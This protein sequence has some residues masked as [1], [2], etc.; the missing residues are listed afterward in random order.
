VKTEPVFY[1]KNLKAD[2]MFMDDRKSKTDS[3]DKGYVHVYTGNGKGKTTAAIGLAIRAAGAGFKVFIA[4]FMKN[5]EYSE[6]KALKRF[7]DSIFIEQFGTGRFIGKTASRLDCEESRRGLDKVRQV[8]LSGKYQLVILEEAN[9]AVMC[10]LL[11]VND[12]LDIISIKP[13]NLELVLTGRYAAPR[14]VES[15]DLVTEMKEVKH[16]FQN[17]VMARVGIEK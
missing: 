13:D 10:G 8:L 4:Q 6:I 2:V 11:T 9:M 12:L 5:G 15:A 14:I 1:R 7:S 3:L 17:G 16:Y